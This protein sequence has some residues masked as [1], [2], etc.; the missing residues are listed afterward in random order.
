MPAMKAPTSHELNLNK[1]P[2]PTMNKIPMPTMNK[3]PM[4][5]TPN[6]LFLGSYEYDF[7]AIEREYAATMRRLKAFIIF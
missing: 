3:I 6:K 1:I 7:R 4:P 2:M 5:T